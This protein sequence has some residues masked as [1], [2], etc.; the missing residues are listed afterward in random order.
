M[1]HDDLLQLLLLAV[2]DS[3]RVFRHRDVSEWPKGGLEFFIQ[4]GILRRGSGSLMAEC[5]NCTQPHLERVINLEDADGSSRMFIHCHE[6]MRVEVTPEMCV[7]WDMDPAELAKMIATALDLNKAPKSL[8]NNRLW[9]LGRIP[10]HGKSRD[11]L[12]ARLLCDTDASDTL[13][14]VPRGGGSIVIVPH[15]IPDDRVWPGRVP[16]VV[17]LESLVILDKGKLMIDGVAFIESITNADTEIADRGQVSL[18]QTSKAKVHKEVK[19]VVENMLSQ[20]QL[21]QAYIAFGSID[22]AVDGLKENG[23]EVSRSAIHRALNAKGGYKKVR[24]RGDSGS[25]S[26]I[27]SS[28]PADRGEKFDM[29]TK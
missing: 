2:D 4:L 14:K 19:F 1:T 15:Q 10:W 11:V 6:S 16:A 12:F 22:K 8:Q 21:T 3:G 17:S 25:F 13:C 5:S 23:V 24:E 18:D 29:H 7:C 26:N 20:T 27:V 9:R 28:H